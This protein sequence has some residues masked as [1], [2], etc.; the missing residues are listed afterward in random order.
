MYIYL[1][2]R[3]IRKPIARDAVTGSKIFAWNCQEYLPGIDR[4]IFP[5][6]FSRKRYSQTAFLDMRK[7][8]MFIFAACTFHA[9]IYA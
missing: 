9:L 5:G 8:N 7:Y 6:I 1:C 4:K 3:C 2:R